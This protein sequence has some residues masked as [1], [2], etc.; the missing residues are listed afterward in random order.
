MKVLIVGGGSA[1]WMSAATLKCLFPEYS[2]QL[3]ESPAIPSVG[4]G[5]STITGFIEWLHILNINPEE[6]VK[7]CNGTY[8]LAI[9]FQ[10]FFQEND[11]GFFY[12]FGPSQISTINTFMWQLSQSEPFSDAM[13][14]NMSLVRKNKFKKTTSDNYALHFD[15]TLFAKYLRDE[16]CL[17]RG[18]EYFQNEIVEVRKNVDGGV[19][20]V[21]CVDGSELRGD[22]YI[23]CTGFKS[24]LLGKT[25]NEPFQ[26]YEHMIPNNT[27]WATHIPYKDKEKECVAYTNCTALKNGWVWNIPLWENIGTGYVFSNEFIS[28]ED[29]LEE[30]KTHLGDTTG[31]K[32][33]KISF[34]SGHY[35]RNWV[36]NVVAVGLSSGFIEPLESS[37]LWTVYSTLIYLA[38]ILERKYFNE[39]DKNVFNSTIKNEFKQWFEFVALHYALSTRTDSDYWRKISKNPFEPNLSEIFTGNSSLATAACSRLYKSDFINFKNFTCIAMGMKWF[40]SDRILA[41]TYLFKTGETYPEHWKKSSQIMKNNK[42]LWDQEADESSN[43]YDYLNNVHN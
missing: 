19:E 13:F 16:Y 33:R 5:E 32:F 6:V 4:V 18:V 7:R 15:A 23:D 27:A 12:P 20:C 17:P 40:C 31:V 9:H 21:V 24:L 11:D 42:M 26:S 3:V 14:S 43:L 38:R 1:G 2:V 34:Q 29:A 35:E 10:N 37:G 22:L 30:F 25:L 41:K 39:W 36:K 8:K 28:D